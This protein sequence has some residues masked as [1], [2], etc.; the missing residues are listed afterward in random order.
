MQMWLFSFLAFVMPF[1]SA[2]LRF[3][4]FPFQILAKNQ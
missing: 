1:G 2:S 3:Y 4:L